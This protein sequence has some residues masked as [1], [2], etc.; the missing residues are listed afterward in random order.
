AA[1]IAALAAEGRAPKTTRKLAA[2]VT[3]AKGLGPGRARKADPFA[4]HPAT[5]T[6]QALRIVVNSERESLVELLDALPRLLRPGGRAVLLTF[7]SGEE[8]LVGKALSEHAAAG[9]WAE[10]VQAPLKPSPAEVRE[11]PRARSARLW[12][13][14]RR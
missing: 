8:A 9:L 5:R 3:E 4:P 10:P 7:H 13:A 11:N 12:R 6:F 14:V 1:V 2:A